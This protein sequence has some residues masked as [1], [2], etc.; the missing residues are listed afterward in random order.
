MKKDDDIHPS[1][2]LSSYDD[3]DS[4]TSTT[5]SSSSFR[6][7]LPDSFDETLDLSVVLVGGA[8]S[9]SSENKATETSSI[10]AVETDSHGLRAKLE[11]SAK[12]IAALR[13]QIAVANTNASPIAQGYSDVKQLQCRILSYLGRKGKEYKV[14]L[15]TNGN[16]FEEA[17]DRVFNMKQQLQEQEKKFRLIETDKE[18]LKKEIADLKEKENEH[19]S[20]VTEKESIFQEALV[21]I[22]LLEAELAKEKVDNKAAYDAKLSAQIVAAREEFKVE[23]S[24]IEDVQDRSQDREHQLLREA[25][26]DA[27]R[28][29]ELL[30]G[31]LNE[32]RCSHQ[33][34]ILCHNRSTTQA[35]KCLA[36]ARSDLKVKTF[37]C[38][39]IIHLQESIKTELVA[40]RVQKVAVET[41]L[42]DRNQQ[43]SELRQQSSAEIESLKKQNSKHVDE[44]EMYVQAEIQVETAINAG[45]DPGNAALLSCPKKRVQQALLLAK[46]CSSLQ[47]K[48]RSQEEIN[49]TTQK[50]LEASE[51]A[52]KDLTQPSAFIIKCAKAKESEISKLH[53][54]NKLLLDEIN[55]LK[56]EN[57]EIKHQLSEV[58]DR[59]HQLDDMKKLVQVI[60]E[61]RDKSNSTKRG[62]GKND[63]HSVHTTHHE[64]QGAHVDW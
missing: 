49:L 20:E 14:N 36:E 11:E 47:L 23:I 22:D 9:T 44:L 42:N 30:Q 38:A 1:H 46:K 4:S 51:R 19:R 10:A 50:Q 3:C 32:L 6:L 54:H 48:L 31:Q 5:T 63:L 2:P 60:G 7:S 64:S 13:R 43:L 16:V 59:R 62:T 34:I 40:M 25:R 58:L 53:S 17:P 8:R 24:R 56:R 39:N 41:D 27:L 29:V 37:E 28:N 18:Y 12:I 52:I 55:T 35:E 33:D 57:L 21:R 15:Q 26:D 61:E 45:K